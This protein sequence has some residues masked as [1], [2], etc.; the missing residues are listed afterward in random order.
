M[1]AG[2]AHLDPYLSMLWRGPATL[3]VG[4]D[5]D[6]AV[7][8]D[9]VSAGLPELLGLLSEP[10]SAQIATEHSRLVGLDAELARAQALLSAARLLST[11]DPQVAV[12]SAWV[13]VVGSGP[14][15][16]QV[17]GSLRATGVGRCSVADEPTAGTPDLVVVAPDRGRGLSHADRLVGSGTPHLWA[18][19]RDGRAVVGPLVVPGRTCCLRCLD[20][21]RC[22]TDPAWPSLALA[23]EHAPALSP[24]R[25]TVHLIA[26]VA[27]R[28]ALRWLG[29][30]PATVVDATLEEQPGGEV[31]RRP[32]AVHP[33]C[34]CGWS[35][36]AAEAVE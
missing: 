12:S 21:H 25:P 29:G 14:V 10:S 5:P 6:R 20:L 7:A 36:D 34:G 9:G 22:D 33:A 26:G 35:P 18:H 15:A 31:L 17:V 28:Q 11:I 23:W 19:L 1:A 27:V 16:A 2:P 30:E 32:W 8:L 4:L 24:T 13:E 3:Q